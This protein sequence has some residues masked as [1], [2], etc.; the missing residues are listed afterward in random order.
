[1][2]A[3]D[4]LKTVKETFES[5][6]K[7]WIKHR[8][9]DVDADNVACGWCLLGGINHFSAQEEEAI[10]ARGALYELLIEE[11][12]VKSL[13]AWNDRPERN[14]KQVLNLLERGMEKLGA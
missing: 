5:N 10:A 6:P 3:Y 1:M 2:S 13:V 9:R 12:F 4:V 7:A 14:L 8:S 11:G